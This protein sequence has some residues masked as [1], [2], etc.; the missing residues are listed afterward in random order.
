MGKIE[1]VQKKL[2]EKEVDGWLLYEFHGVNPL[3]LNFLEIPE[4][5]LLTRRC[6]YWI[7]A[8]GTPLKIVHQIEAQNLDHLPG[9]KKIYGDWTLLHEHLRQLL[10]EKSKVAM[11]YSPMQAIPTISKVDGGLIDLIRSFGPKIVSSAPFLQ[12]FTSVWTFHQYELH[13]EAAGVLEGAVTHVWNHIRLCL[14]KGKEVTEYDIQQMILREFKAN[15]CVTEGDPICGV[16]ANAADPHYVPTKDNSTPIKKGD[17]IL[18]DLWCKK[19]VEGAV[20]ADITRMGVA[21]FEPTP[22]QAEVFSVVRKAQ[23]TGTDWIAAE[24]KA[25]RE[26]PGYKVDNLV[27]KVIEESGYGKYFTHRTGHN[28]DREIH[29]P[30]S[31]IDGL[32][33]QDDRPLI[34]NTCFSIEPGIYLPGE[35]G[36][37]LEYDIFMHEGGEIEVTVPPQDAFMVF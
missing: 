1:T 20:F 25:G 23:K 28:I 33:T 12:E 19:N 30:G 27:R 37:R 36:V 7:P 29:G 18:I 9:E 31:N 15:H 13:K 35:F 4:G 26:I 3:A 10:K 16:N 8:N 17:L 2:R 6:F 5:L 14:E 34:P 24:H 32:E 21:A 22:K 11:E